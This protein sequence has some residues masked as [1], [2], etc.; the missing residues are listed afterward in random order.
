LR[1]YKNILRTTGIRPGPSSVHWVAT[2]RCNAHCLYCEASANEVEC[3]ELSTEQIK[4]T[5]S[6]LAELRVRYFYVTGGEPLLRKDVFEV[7]HH[8]KAQRMKIGFVTNSILFEKYKTDFGKARFDIIWTSVDGI[9]KTHDRNRGYKGAYEK[10]LAAIKFYKNINIPIR[11]VNTVVNQ[12]NFHELPE[13]FEALKAAGMN[14]WR[15]ALTAPVGRAKDGNWALSNDNL[16]KL[17]QFASK[18]RKHFPVDLSEQLGYL[19]CWDRQVRESPFYCPSGLDRCVIMPDGNVLPCQMVYDTSYSEGNV[20]EKLFK[21]IWKE[22]F[23]SL[24]HVRL[25][26][27]CAKCSHQK[28]C[29]GGCWAQRVMG[30]RCLKNIWESEA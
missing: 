1:W 2:Y 14:R 8:A 30:N 20:K 13:L 7:I 10:I 23:T 11:A 12:D 25:E 19:G 24:R 3:E 9:L 22:G 16:L 18:M 28:A 15:L 5:V 21:E 17:F 6:Q 26:G 27:E 4:Y 29:G